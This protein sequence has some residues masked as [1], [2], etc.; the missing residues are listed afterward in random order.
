VLR[1]VGAR[2]VDWE[3]IAAGP[4]PV[5]DRLYLYVGDLGDNNS[6]R[7]EI[8]V[9]RIP[10]PTS[11][12]DKSSKARPQVS[13]AAEVIRLRYP[14][15]SHDAEALLVHPSSGD[16]YIVN[17][18]TFASPSVY[19]AAAPLS[20]NK[21]ITLTRLGDLKLPSLFGG[22]ITGGDIS[23]SGTRVALCDYFGGYE[24]VLGQSSK[25]FDDIWKG[26][27]VSITWASK[28]RGNCLSAMGRLC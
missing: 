19:K 18:V 28:S 6:V 21:V 27:F 4:G 15:G 26:R 8:V 9:Y 3:D 14:D 7:S 16:L 17:K 11:L 2:A 24:A 10:E 12:D 20:T 5:R 25:T 13:Q 23:P 22:I 1:V